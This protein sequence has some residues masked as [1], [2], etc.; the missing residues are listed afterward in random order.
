MEI[1]T[2]MGMKI[3]GKSGKKSW[4]AMKMVMRSKTSETWLPR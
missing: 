3:V 1:E 4:K 2:A